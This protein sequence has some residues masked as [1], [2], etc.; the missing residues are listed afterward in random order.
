MQ[1]PFS[2]KRNMVYLGGISFIFGVMIGAFLTIYFSSRLLPFLQ[3]Y[4][5]VPAPPTYTPY[6]TF[7][8]YP[9][10]ILTPTNLPTPSNTPI[11]GTFENPVLIG[12]EYLLPGYG[13]MT[14]MGSNW[15]TEQ[16]GLAII[17]LSFTC[18]R[19]QNQTC[20]TNDFILEAIG[21]TGKV[22]PRD[23]TAEIPKPKFSEFGHS[24][25]RGGETTK[26]FVGFLITQPESTLVLHV[27]VLFQDTEA[28]FKISY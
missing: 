8:P 9:T 2:E 16:L 1:N 19:P 7:T 20:N 11:I 15:G 14:V 27:R 21:E 18:D 4:A 26:G 3:Q 25:I 24:E 13:R 12:R 28:F 5:I 22:Y 23:F 10:P 6:P 17:Y